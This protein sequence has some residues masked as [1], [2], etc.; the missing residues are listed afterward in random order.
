MHDLFIL[1]NCGKMPGKAKHTAYRSVG[2][3]LRRKLSNCRRG[4]DALTRHDSCR[5][6]DQSPIYQTEP[7]DYKDQDWFVNY[8]VKIETTLDPFSLLDILKSI[9]RSA[10]RARDGVRFGPRVLDL[11]IILYDAI[12]LD[13]SNLV[14][15]HPRMYRR[16]FVLVPLAEIAPRKEHPVLKKTVAALLSECP[17]G[18]S[19]KRVS[20]APGAERGASEFSRLLSKRIS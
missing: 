17:P 11:D 14:I 10:G 9:E 2:S 19:V 16:R 5:L 6:I 8:V 1:L 3:N 15:P 13:S 18:G 7:V 12:I 20:A 4:I